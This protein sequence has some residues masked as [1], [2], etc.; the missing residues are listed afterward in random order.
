MRG[1]RAV[2][3]CNPAIAAM[4]LMAQEMNY[5]KWKYLSYGVFSPS[6]SIF[7]SFETANVAGTVNAELLLV[8]LHLLTPSEVFNLFQK[9]ENGFNIDAICALQLFAAKSVS[10]H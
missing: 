9:S 6:L 7:I 4:I 1:S 3:M 8:L 2:G 5:A 10:F